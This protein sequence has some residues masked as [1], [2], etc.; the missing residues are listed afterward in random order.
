MRT[1]ALSWIIGVLLLAAALPAGAQRQCDAIVQQ[2][3]LLVDATCAPTG[4]NQ[5][6]H[7][8]LRVDADPQPMIDRFRFAL[9]DIVD[10]ADIAALRTSPLNEERGEWGVALLRLQANLPDVL[11]GT[12]TTFLIFGGAQVDQIDAQTMQAFRLETGVFGTR[13]ESVPPD[14]LLLESPYGFSNVHFTVNGVDFTLRAAAA[15]VQ[16][17]PGDALT[18]RVLDGTVTLAAYETAQTARRG[19][20]LRVPMNEAL[21]PAGPVEAPVAYEL[22]LVGRLPLALLDRALTPAGARAETAG[23]AAAMLTGVTTEAAGAANPSPSN[24]AAAPATATPAGG[25]P[26]LGDQAGQSGNVFTGN[27]GQGAGVGVGRGCSNDGGQPQP[28][29]HGGDNPGHGGEPPGR[30]RRG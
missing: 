10:V 2:A 24:T 16:A 21:T 12:N 26:Q 19:E 1:K 7:G 23:D 6:C 11:P 28:P 18:V 25:P 5:A 20:M 17:T 3:L 29:G 8:Y 27:C 14:G 4:R 22:S 9:G 13:C 30:G 15:F